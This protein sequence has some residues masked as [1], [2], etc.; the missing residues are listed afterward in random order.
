MTA[1]P[2]DGLV[3]RER[4]LAVLQ[5]ALRTA[6][7]GRSGVTLV[8]GEPGIGKTRL[9]DEAATIA[10]AAGM[11]VLRGEADRTWRDPMELWRGVHRSLGIE[12]IPDPTL[13]AETRRWDHL[14]SLAD[15][16]S[17]CAPALVL[18]EDLHWSDPTAIWVLQHLPRAVDDAPIAFVASS[19]DHEPDAARM[20]DLRRSS[21]LISLAGLDVDAVR[22]LV[23]AEAPGSSDRQIDADDLHARTGGNPLFVQELVRSP[24]GSGVVS[25]LLHGSFERFDDATQHGLAIAATAGPDTPLETIAAATDRSGGSLVALLSPALRD[26]V[27]ADVSPGGVRF[28][29][30]LLAEAAANLG[31][32]HQ[33]H[34]RLAAAWDVV[35]GLAARASAAGHRIRAATSAAETAEAV[36]TT[37][38]VAAELVV[39]DQQAPRRGDS[40]PTPGPSPTPRWCGPSCG[41]GWRWTWPTC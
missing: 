13:P 29:H 14:E 9:L 4:E 1:A 38:E 19:R 7:T 32:P 15:A 10:R 21:R 31:E 12:P 36:E 3:G 6:R 23:A 28:R 40:S 17:A 33:L 11:R 35:D 26:G 25:E 37:C 2:P 39:S 8:V 27:L 20:D 24:G 34:A 41:R 30:A 5:E 18:L 16:L 22:Q